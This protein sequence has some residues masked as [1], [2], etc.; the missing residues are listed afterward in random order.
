M[1]SEQMNPLDAGSEETSIRVEGTDRVTLE[2]SAP[3]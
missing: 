3:T 2:R 1:V